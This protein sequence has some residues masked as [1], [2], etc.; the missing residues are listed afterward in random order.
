MTTNN[1]AIIIGVNKYWKPEKCLKG[2][3]GDAARVAEWLLGSDV[4][5]VPPENMYLLTSPPPE[6]APPGV[7]LRDAT[8]DNLKL[9]MAEVNDRSGGQGDRF[10]FYFSGHGISN[11]E[12]F[13]NEQALVMTDFR[14][15][16]EDKAM[17]LAPVVEFFGATAFAE[18]FFFIDAC[19]NPADFGYEFE[20]GSTTRKNQL[21]AVRA[22][23]VDQYIL[24]ST[25]PG[26]KSK[27]LAAAAGASGTEEGAFTGVL[28]EGIGGDGT[29]KYYDSKSGDYV[30][31]AE[32][33]MNYVIEKVSDLKLIVSKR[34]PT[35]PVLIQL[36]QKGGNR[37]NNNPVL[38]RVPASEVKPESLEL[39]VEPDSVWPHAEVVIRSEDFDDPPPIKPVPGAPVTL[40]KLKPM[41]YDLRAT[42]PDHAASKDSINLYKPGKVTL[43][44]KPGA[45]I[46]K[47]DEA[48]D[49]VS[50]DGDFGGFDGG[51]GG[52][53]R[54]GA[55]VEEGAVL[56]RVREDA[57]ESDEGDFDI[58]TGAA[59]T[60]RLVVEA[61]DPL[62]PLELS[63][64]TGHVLLAGQGRLDV[65]DMEPG[66]YQVRLLTPEG[67][68]VEQ[69]ISLTAGEV[70]RKELRAPDP[71][72]TRL[73]EEI[74]STAN[75][76]IQGDKTLDVS[77]AVGPIASAQLSTIL[78]LA[79]T[80]CNHNDSWGARLKSLGLKSFREATSDDADC[81]LQL[82]AGIEADGDA[83]ASELLAGARL[84][85]WPFGRPV[86]EA[87]DAPSP[88]PSVAGVAQYA[89]AA[90]PG[91]HWLSIEMPGQR[92]VVF[93]LTLLPGRLTLLVAHLD[94]AGDAR[95][96]QYESESEPARFAT[97]MQVRRLEII[98]RFYL[99][100]RLEHAYDIAGEAM[101]EETQDPL[102]LCLRGYLALK[103]DHPEEA[104]AAGRRLVEL[105]ETLSD[106]YVI[107]GEVMAANGNEEGAVEAY[108]RAFLSGL[109]VF[110]EGL[111]RLHNAAGLRANSTLV[112]SGGLLQFSIFATGKRILDRV[113]ARQVGGLLWTALSL[114]DDELRPG[115]TLL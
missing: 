26:S 52:G 49:P 6:K 82:V 5:G 93:A 37:S 33:L 63:D 91:P 25:T 31:R 112:S 114:S 46:I 42:A 92:P 29:A 66:F 67:E 15:G 73:F 87:A 56:F 57:F 71:P 105:H 59:A 51:S 4:C 70:E 21:D 23:K 3:V 1:W 97:P 102:L 88:L 41:K 47:K 100:G 27:E 8:A 48:P 74:V 14:E 32:Q 58:L 11:R 106:G 84:R 28:L 2:A 20:T 50:D 34:D 113:V 10:F 44:L 110:A 12:R 83:E 89:E 103:L 22:S 77:E 36:P 94:A 54:G 17:K 109:P 61:S 90:T 35:K 16:L 111:T 38:A 64:S 45:V 68:T 18:Q 69:V 115:A 60:A 30:V 96:F 95:V 9:V 76:L 80:A 86:P 101:R 104:A 107:L 81:G 13:S 85:L 108:R 98:E 53:S 39:F 79:L 55:A 7:D 19:R 99:S 43:E 40:T 24:F 78:A 62:S 72:H 65:E 75:F